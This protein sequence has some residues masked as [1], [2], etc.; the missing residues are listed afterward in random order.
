MRG[1]KGRSKRMVTMKNGKE[2]EEVICSAVSQRF[3]RGSSADCRFSQ[4]QVADRFVEGN[5]GGLASS[6]FC[7]VA[8]KI[9]V[10][11]CAMRKTVLAFG[12]LKISKDHTSEACPA[13]EETRHSSACL[14][15]AARKA[16]H[17]EVSSL[18]FH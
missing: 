5:A 3:H 11:V 4:I 6:F 15:S 7:V 16:A 18:G 17:G 2:H 8:T 12:I 13:S 9:G 14:M 1:G 10:D